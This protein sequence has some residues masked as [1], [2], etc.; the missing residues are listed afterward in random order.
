MKDK[1]MNGPS[2]FI[3]AG[4]PSMRQHINMFLRDYSEYGTDEAVNSFFHANV[5][6]FLTSAGI[7]IREDKKVDERVINVYVKLLDRI[8]SKKYLQDCE[9]YVDSGGYQ[10]QCGMV[11]R[12]EIPTFIDLYYN[13]FLENNHQKISYAFTL[14]LAPGYKAC[15]YHSWE[16][17]KELNIESYSR[18]A[19]LPKEIKDKMIFINHFRTPKL[20]KIYKELFDTFATGFSHFGTG[21][22]VSMSSIKNPPPCVMY[23]VPLMDVIDHA[24]KNNL[25]NVTFHALGETEFK[26]MFTHCFFE[27]HVK[28]KF[29]ID[30]KITYDSSSIFKSL[31]MGRFTYHLDP[32]DL[33]IW[34]VDLRSDYCDNIYRNSPLSNADV[35]YN[36]VNDAVVPHGMKTVGTKN[37]LLYYD[38]GKFNNLFYA[39]G[40]FQMFNTFKQVQS[41]CYKIVDKLYPLY[42]ADDDI[43][44][45]QYVESWMLKFNNGKS[46]KKVYNRANSIYNSLKMLDN[47][48][49]DYCDF[50]VEHHMSCEENDDIPDTHICG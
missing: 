14:D 46:S 17:L 33:T 1:I 13:N 34:K 47:M 36:E 21:G 39:Y 45:N 35:F 15:P 48:D 6:K 44:F 40:I 27:K 19:N 28:E 3:S 11:E 18:A 32:S 16:D 50:L 5:N 29:G 37:D 49:F 2:S 41:L 30:L 25:K 10:I 42:V 43:S 22:L 23:T 12:E 9:I 38:D 24:V 20:R 8:L 31:G 26:S 4:L 7:Y